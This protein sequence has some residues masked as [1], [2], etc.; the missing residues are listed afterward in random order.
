MALGRTQ[1]WLMKGSR[2]AALFLL[3]SLQ[4]SRLLHNTLGAANLA[5]DL[6]SG[7][8]S[9]LDSPGLEFPVGTRLLDQSCKPVL[10]ESVR[11]LT[12]GE[13]IGKVT[14]ER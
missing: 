4:L 5:L 14:M 12:V 6:L 10:A 3:S 9:G 11:K 1:A 2:G 8:A 7:P 13:G